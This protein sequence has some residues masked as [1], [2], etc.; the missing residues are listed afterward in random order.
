M[1]KIKICS[2][3]GVSVILSITTIVPQIQGER[4]QRKKETLLENPSEEGFA[5]DKASLFF[6]V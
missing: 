3:V 6:L 2:C 4:E 1:D 5:T